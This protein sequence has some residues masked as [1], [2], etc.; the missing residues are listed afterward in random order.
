MLSLVI[1]PGKPGSQAGS[2]GYESKI[3]I[4]TWIAQIQ[5][6]TYMDSPNGVETMLQARAR[7]KRTYTDIHFCLSLFLFS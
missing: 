7:S 1:I 5:P 4:S 2:L 3:A 6:Q